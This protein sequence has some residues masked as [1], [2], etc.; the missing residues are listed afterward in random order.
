[1]CNIAGY[2]GKKQAAPILCEMMKKQEYF[3]G[4]YYTGIT[5]HDGNKLQT[6]KVVGNME[7]LLNETDAVHLKGNIGFLHSRSKG[8]GDVEWGHPFTNR[9]GSLSYIANGGF[10]GFES[11]DLFQKRGALATELENKGYLF[12]SKV[13]E[14]MKG[15]PNLENGGTVHCSDLQCQHIASLIDEGLSPS[16]AMAKS[17]S[18]YP[19][20]IVGLCMHESEPE[21]VFVTRLTCPMN[22]GITDDGDT[23]FATTVFAF[24]D[25]VCFK[26]IQ[27][28]PAATVYELFQGGYK[29]TDCPVEVHN[30]LPLTPALWHNAY[31]EVEKMLTG[32]KDNPAG[33]QEVW[34][35][36][37][38]LKKEGFV[39]QTDCMTYG[40]L[41]ALQQ[42]GK[43]NIVSV[44]D[45]GAF[46]GYNTTRYCFYVE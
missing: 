12:R 26:T 14:N 43:L 4:G 44:P 5:V 16:E 17:N 34:D 15:Y 23:Y 41:E 25:D 21:K 39:L 19:S 18:L 29:A 37:Y 11:E 6:A 28:L 20:A 32:R 10:K 38:T 42:N 30:I 9:D 45:T 3:W 22:V 35:T 2:I 24:P 1:M 7:N 27:L 8:G 46:E 36:C 33:I 40:V 31:V 13:A